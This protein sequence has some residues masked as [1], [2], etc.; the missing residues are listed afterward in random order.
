M[1]EDQFIHVKNTAEFQEQLKLGEISPDSIA[2]C[3]DTDYIYAKGHYYTCVN[4]DDLNT[5]DLSY[6]DIYGE[7]QSTQNTANCYVVRTAGYYRLPL[8]YGNGI[9]NGKINSAAYTN[10]D[11]TNT[12]L[13]N[14]VNVKGVQ[15]TSP[16]IYEDL[17]V[18]C[19]DLTAQF[20]IGD[21]DIFTN[22]RIANGY[23]CFKVTNVP[24]GG[25]NGILSV[26]MPDGT[27]AWSWH[28]WVFEEDLSTVTVTTDTGVEYDM[29]PVFLATTYDNGDP[30]KRKNWFYQWG[31]PTPQLGPK[32]YN[33]N[34][35]ATS[36]GQ[37]ERDT[38][39][40]LH[41]DRTYSDC[42]A[43]PS[44]FFTES[45]IHTWFAYQFYYNLWDASCSS[46]GYSDNNSIKTIYDPS[47][48]GF[49][50]P[51]ATLYTGLVKH[52][53]KKTNNG[54]YLS[55]T[56][57]SEPSIFFPY[58]GQLNR[59]YGG[60]SNIGSDGYVFSNSS[61]EQRSYNLE[62]SNSKII[63]NNDSPETM[64]ASVCCIVDK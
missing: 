21:A 38:N 6:V 24:T 5:I 40:N 12:H 57:S 18:D 31:R 25:A 62:Y 30:L 15:I 33:S 52:T 27:I 20:S 63:L 28:I 50:V 29:L 61:S 37:L 53:V 42:I 3:E 55:P 22:L 49:K 51:S 46:Q 35:F 44:T 1:I 56:E 10:I 32:A 16:Y 34:T 26:V 17:N 59:Q 7:K 45:E 8:V 58:S 19:S 48:V 14:F 9:K 36:Y 13:M 4:N 54:L 47:P 11:S 39:H 64:G 41:G 2:F 43:N 23:L 60:I